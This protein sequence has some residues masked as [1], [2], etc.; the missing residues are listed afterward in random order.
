M[1]KICVVIPT[2]NEKNNIAKLLELIFSQAI[3]GL[4]VLVV[5]DN[6]PDGTGELVEALRVGNLRLNILHRT[7]KSGLGRAY[8]DGFK[9]ALATGA[10]LILEM[11]AD[12]SHDPKY[13]PA[14]LAAAEQY[15]LVI[16]S[17]YIRG[18]GVDNWSL[19][20]RLISRFGNLYAR[21][22]LGLSV[23]DLTGGYKCYRR[24]VLETIGLDNLSSVGYNF[25]I[26]T[27]YEAIKSGFSVGEVP[28]VFV[29]RASG[30]SKFSLA[31]MLESFWKVLILRI[32]SKRK[33]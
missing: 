17:R 25:Q 15:D 1:T 28:I 24:K 10:D 14:I 12:L 30:K 8:I 2:Y 29:E 6:S 22:I 23:S 3:E 18:G 5:D 33:K 21:V 31:I 19:G 13:L 4:N 7:T 27:T 26:E 20:R 16:G 32:N 11:D 9:Q